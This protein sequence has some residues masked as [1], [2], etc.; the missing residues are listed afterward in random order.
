MP[1][2]TTSKL[3]EISVAPLTNEDTE[4]VRQISLP[5]QQVKFAGT[6]DEF[7]AEDSETIHRHVIK[8]QWLRAGSDLHT[9]CKQIAQIMSVLFVGGLST[10]TSYAQGLDF[11]VET[12]GVAFSKNDVSI[13]GDTGTRFDMTDLT[14]QSAT[15]YVRLYGTYHFNPQHAVRLT[16]AP[17]SVDGRG[18]LSK[19]IQFQDQRFAAGQAID[20]DYQFN[21]YR[22]TYRWTFYDQGPW[23]WG[24]GAAALVRD[25]EIT[26]A[27]GETKA[28]KSN[29]GVVPLLHGYGQYR[30]S[31]R[32]ALILD[33]EGAW[34]PMGRA[35]DAALML[36]YHLGDG[37]YGALGY[38]T[39]EGGAD[40]DE[41]YN[42]SWLHYGLASL[43]YRF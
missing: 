37:W 17:L 18:T 21:T 40:N 28:T 14:G 11:R 26:L 12:G 36:E 3:A 42:F 32:A 29:V 20:A 1:A 13:P 15:P 10:G 25:A 5:D 31:D 16:F 43:R 35:V 41:V 30:L 27:Q 24:V 4:G 22:A 6:A 23:Q 8:R 19:S 38:R 9:M 2:A 34:S 7:L 39:L 33:V